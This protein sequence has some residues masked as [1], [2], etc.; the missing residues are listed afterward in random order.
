MKIV[1]QVGTILLSDTNMP[2]WTATV[3]TAAF[4]FI[5]IAELNEWIFP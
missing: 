5:L 2:S 1:N 4:S 3:A